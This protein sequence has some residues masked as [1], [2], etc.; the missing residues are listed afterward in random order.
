[1]DSWASSRLGRLL[2]GPEQDPHEYP[3]LLPKG[4]FSWEWTLKQVGARNS[5]CR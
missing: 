3:M 4:V 1:M 5:W 2:C